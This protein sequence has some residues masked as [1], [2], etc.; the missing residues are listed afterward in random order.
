MQLQQAHELQ[1][2]LE[3]PKPA[4]DLPVIPWEEF[5]E[6]SKTRPLICVSGFIHDVSSLVDEHPG[7]R[8][9]LMGRIGKDATSAFNGGVYEHS[10]AAHNLLSMM[11]VGVLS[12][13]ME[14]ASRKQNHVPSATPLLWGDSSNMTS[15]E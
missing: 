5:K 9:L 15:S 12:G 11:R 4:S 3:Y 6:E 1:E 14:I 8:A 7:G 13:G 2:K 10:N